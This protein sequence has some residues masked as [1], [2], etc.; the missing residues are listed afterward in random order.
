MRKIR[1]GK[2]NRAFIN[3]NTASRVMPIKRNGRD[4]NQING[5]RI[6]AIRASGQHNVSNMH[7]AINSTIVFLL[8]YQQDNDRN[9]I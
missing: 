6:N 7:Q 1:A 3:S 2:N 5:I 9:V 8:K 4:T